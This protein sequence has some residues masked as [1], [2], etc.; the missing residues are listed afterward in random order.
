MKKTVGI[1][2][3]QRVINY[4][5]YLQAYALRQLLLKQGAESVEFIDIR[6]GRSLKGFQS[7]GF[8]YY[9]RRMKALMKIIVAGRIFEKRKTRAFMRSVTESLQVAW[10]DLG[11]QDFPNY[12]NVDLAVIG[13]DEVFHCCQSTSWGFTSQLFGNIKEAKEVV[14]YAASFGGTKLDDIIRLGIGDEIAKNLRMMKYISVRD[15]NSHSIIKALTGRN[16]EI[17]IDPVLAYGFKKEIVETEPVDENSYILIYSYPDRINDKKEIKAI[18]DFAKTTGKKLIC[19]MSCY[20]WCDRAVITSPLELLG[21]FKNADMIITET[22]HG[23]IF[24]IITER[25]FATIGRE[26]A[27]SKL[28][29]MLQPY[30]LENRLVSKDNSF[31][32]IFSKRIDYSV[33]NKV[34]ENLRADTS[35]Y[36][37]KILH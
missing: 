31:N 23:T 33:L 26:S 7:S 19:V 5:S 34:L 32:Q 22:F 36:I 14:S 35:L 10:K 11:L 17:N 30:G 6:R 20:D 4:G 13:S 37:D 18:T 12:P 21:W 24:S 28:T 29:S 2:S 15:E 25:Q 3:M 16:A 27:M 8:P 9:I 1:L